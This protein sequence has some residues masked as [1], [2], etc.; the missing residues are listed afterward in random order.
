MQ[1]HYLVAFRASLVELDSSVPTVKPYAAR[2]VDRDFTKINLAKGCASP[3]TRENTV[4]FRVTQSAN[5]AL[6]GKSLNFLQHPAALCALQ[7]RFL[8]NCQ[9]P[10]YVPNVHPVMRNHSPVKR[11]AL[12]VRK[13]NLRPHQDFLNVSCVL[14]AVSPIRALLFNATSALQ[15]FEVKL[16]RQMEL[17]PVL[18]RSV[19]LAYSQPGKEHPLVYRVQMVFIASKPAASHVKLVIPSMKIQAIVPPVKLVNFQALRP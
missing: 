2:N 7:G 15:A 13:D 4:S 16:L 1:G 19:Q 3:A 10:K 6:Q 9:V 8:R 5:Y 18:V 11:T 12:H 14:L 17:V